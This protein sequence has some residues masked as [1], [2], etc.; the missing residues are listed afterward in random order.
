MKNND[1]DTIFKELDFDIEE[2]HSGHR[3]R[4][5]KKLENEANE[6]ENKGK[7]RRLWAPI[8]GIAASFL[9]AFFLLGEFIA[10]TASAKNT[11]LASISPEMKQTQ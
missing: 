3:E 2:P 7:V 4:F 1:F 11:D 9:L 6:P 8:M 5:F 10:P